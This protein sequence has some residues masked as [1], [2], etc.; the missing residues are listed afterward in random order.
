MA[1]A[2]FVLF[3]VFSTAA[4]AMLLTLDLRW[5]DGTLMGPVETADAYHLQEGSI[6]QVIG[7]KQGAPG[8]SNYN[9]S[10]S[11]QFEKF[12]TTSDTTTSAQPYT[13]GHVPGE[14]DVYL[15]DS[16]QPGH[17]ILYT[18][19]IQ[20][21]GT[22]YG[23]YTQITVDDWM[24]DRVYIRVFGATEIKAGEVVASYWGISSVHTNTPI[25]QTDTLSVTNLVANNLNYFE[26]IPEPAT[27]GLLGLGG[28]A[29]AAWRRRRIL[30]TGANGTVRE[31]D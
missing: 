29:L 30:R 27:L 10:V 2:L 18:G 22:W 5:T 9:A 19:A 31:E 7:F 23:L 26:V 28:V 16:T 11:A 21:N 25:Y 6:I 8:T 15:A 20:N 4:Q 14:K 17:D 24:Y 12:G 1:L 3:A 13:Q